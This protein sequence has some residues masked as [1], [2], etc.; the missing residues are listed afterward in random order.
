MRGRYRTSR[1]EQTPDTTEQENGESRKQRSSL[2]SPGT[3]VERDSAG[4]PV[5]YFIGVDSLLQ[6]CSSTRGLSLELAL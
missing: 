2:H 1:Q 5:F 3:Y 4:F 6:Y